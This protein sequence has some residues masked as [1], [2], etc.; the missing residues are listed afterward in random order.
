MFRH[1]QALAV[2]LLIGITAVLAVSNATGQIAL[3]LK[4]PERNFGDVLC[5]GN[6][7]ERYFAATKLGIWEFDKFG[8]VAKKNPNSISAAVFN[9]Q[10]GE[11]I[12]RGSHEHL[13][14]FSPVG[15]S[16]MKLPISS[17][18]YPLKIT[19]NGKFLVAKRYDG[20]VQVFETGKWEALLKKDLMVDR[21]V[22]IELSADGS[23]IVIGYSPRR[24]RD[25]V[26]VFD[27][28]NERIIAESAG[29]IT[30]VK[31]IELLSD[32]QKV[33]ILGTAKGKYGVSTFD[34]STLRQG[35][36]LFA[37]G[38]RKL[39][40]IGPRGLVGL[41]ADRGFIAFDAYSGEKL[42]TIETQDSVFGGD[43]AVAG[44]NKIISG[45]R[46]PLVLEWGS[47]R[48]FISPVKTIRAFPALTSK[49][50]KERR[51]DGPSSIELAWHPAGK[52]IAV[53]TPFEGKVSGHSP[54]AASVVN[55]TRDAIADGVNN[56][57]SQR[58]NANSAQY[59]AIRFINYET[60]KQVGQYSPLGGNAFRE[61]EFSPSGKL[62]AC[63]NGKKDFLL[64]D[65]AEQKT[66]TFPFGVSNF[67]FEFDKDEQSVLVFS[68]GQLERTDTRS[69]IGKLISKNVR[70]GSI[71]LLDGNRALCGDRIIDLVTGEIETDLRQHDSVSQVVN[72]ELVITSRNE[73]RDLARWDLEAHEKRIFLAGDFRG[74]TVNSDGSMVAAGYPNGTIKVWDVASRSL[75]GILRGHKKSVDD[76]AFHP[77][78]P[79]LASVSRTG[80]MHFWKLESNIRSQ[81][82]RLQP[83]NLPS[84]FQFELGNGGSLEAHFPTETS[85]AELVQ[86]F[87]GLLSELKTASENGE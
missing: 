69:G 68:Y 78:E 35:K 81:N 73:S 77:S 70:G 5:Y 24:D 37:S 80:N 58:S 26:E 29:L 63:R 79:L 22:A 25:L 55:S 2:F 17:D 27:V 28:T 52:T 42:V 66:R 32:G 59:P 4:A 60:G 39:F 16:S 47:S 45:R 10:K 7:K 61:L 75:I 49:M 8:E 74:F 84:H 57:G 19:D 44:T 36:F 41:T 9:P 3:E 87:E 6:H 71:K 85:K 18:Y 43:Y 62:F 46:R 13:F 54:I 64:L 14:A 56:Y 86:A 38:G 83:K 48:N 34:T 21:H 31:S 53:S 20:K 82:E 30:D 15:Q 40:G 50:I 23:I 67:D 72:E 76:L 51:L 11:F 1:Y 33:V 12:L 65:M